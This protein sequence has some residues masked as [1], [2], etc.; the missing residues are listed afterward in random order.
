MTL[1]VF[2]ALGPASWQPRT[3]L[4]LTLIVILAWPRPLLVGAAL[5]ATS[6]ALECLQA[7][8]PDRSTDLFAATYGAAGVVTAAVL[9][10]GL[11]RIQRKFTRRAQWPAGVALDHSPAADD[12]LSARASGQRARP[13]IK[14]ST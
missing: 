1:L 6:V 14:S 11:I 12:G 7:L 5:V 3:G 9:A 13:S 4:L 2:A 8:T 10:G